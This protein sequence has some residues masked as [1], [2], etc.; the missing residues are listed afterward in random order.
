MDEFERACHTENYTGE[1]SQEN[2]IEWVRGD[3][4]V[5]VT[6]PGSTK[7]NNT[8]R[9]L[10]EKYPDEV[11]IVAIN[12]DGSIVGHLPLKYVKISHPRVLTDEQKQAAAD[13]LSRVRENIIS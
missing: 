11:K 8:V 2:V 12:K 4:E 7:F 9:K 10:A 5:T 1:T 6:F 3:K 13:R